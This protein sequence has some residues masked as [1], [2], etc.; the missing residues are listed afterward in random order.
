M[1]SYGQA[2]GATPGYGSGYSARPAP[3][4]AQP[5]GCENSTRLACAC[6]GFLENT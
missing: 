2:Y 6:V 1:P 5:Q 3:A 4:Y